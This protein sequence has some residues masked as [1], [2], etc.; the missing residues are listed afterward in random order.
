MIKLL[1]FCN[2]SLNTKVLKEEI[3]ATK[4]E[5]IMSNG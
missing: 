1:N 4:I 5:P 3:I 2:F